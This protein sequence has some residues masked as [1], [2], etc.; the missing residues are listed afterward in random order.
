MQKGNKLGISLSTT[1]TMASGDFNEFQKSTV[2]ELELSSPISYLT[3]DN[4]KRNSNLSMIRFV[5][6]QPSL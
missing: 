3:P 6:A 5:N 4:E 1:L 2:P